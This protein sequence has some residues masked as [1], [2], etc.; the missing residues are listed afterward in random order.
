[1]DN[2]GADPSV[3]ELQ[4]DLAGRGTIIYQLPDVVTAGVTWRVLERLTL[5]LQLRWLNYRRHDRFDIRL[6]GR[7]FR[8]RPEVPNQVVHYRGFHDVFAGQLGAAY[9][10]TDRLLLQVATMVESAA[11]STDAVNTMAI[12][13]WKLD[14][15]LALRWRL[16]AGLTVG[17]GYNLVVVP[18][19]SVGS[20]DYHPSYLAECVDSSFNVDLIQCRAAAAGR[21]L[22]STA[23]EYAL[24]T[25]R[26]G[27]SVGYDWW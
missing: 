18:P 19:I 8:K 9:K 27:L 23:G 24:W 17:A 1:V 6:T 15:L 7:E 21:G 5:N 12:D 13:G 14:L 11:L 25:H 20:S 10:L 4:R 26:F 3:E 2:A 16:W 22:A